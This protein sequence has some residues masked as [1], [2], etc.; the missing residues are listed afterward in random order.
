MF[1]FSGLGSQYYQMGRGLFTGHPGFRRLMQD[2]DAVV[3]DL[4]GES[5][6]RTLYDPAYAKSDPFDSLLVSSAALFMVEYALAEA[7]IEVGMV[8]DGVLGVSLGAFAAATIAGCISRDESLEWI[9]RQSQ[10]VQRC[11]GNG[12]M[13]AGRPRAL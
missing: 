6:I 10:I 11:C 2:M 1:M 7:M 5:V 13:I 8:P 4:T 9:I 3:Q 12:G